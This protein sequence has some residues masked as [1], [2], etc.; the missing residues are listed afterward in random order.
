MMKPVAM[1]FVLLS[2]CVV[3]PDGD[4]QLESQHAQAGKADGGA[5]A[6]VVVKDGPLAGLS[7][8][9]VD[10]TGAGP[11]TQNQATEM[12]DSLVLGGHDDW[13]LPPETVLND[14]GTSELA[15]RPG[16]GQ[17]DVWSDFAFIDTNQIGDQGVGFL[18]AQ[19][20]TMT[21]GTQTW[22]RH[23]YDPNQPD[24]SKA[25]EALCV[26]SDKPLPDYQACFALSQV[27][28]CLCLGYEVETDFECN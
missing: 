2:A 14:I 16:F 4:L 13:R 11:L 23:Y 21:L 3:G 22:T 7:I 20:A 19:T 24:A 18:E 15:A 6:V 8:T 17:V 25:F 5:A 27:A 28:R 10:P 12:C 9:R 1:T 26:R